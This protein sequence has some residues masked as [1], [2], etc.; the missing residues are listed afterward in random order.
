MGTEN[1]A[2][3]ALSV[4]NPHPLKLP[5]PDLL[6]HLVRSV[7]ELP[8]LDALDGGTRK[9]YTYQQ[10]HNASE[11]IARRL[12]QAH[13]AREAEFVVPVLVP[14][15]PL[16]YAAL[17]GTLKAGGAFCPLNID[18]PSERVQ[19]ILDDVDASVVVVSRELAD[20]LPPDCSQ[21]IITIEFDQ[22]EPPHTNLIHRRAC[23]EDLAYVMYT[24]GS[25]GTPK[26]VGITHDAATQALL[27]H[28]RHIPT[29]S[30]FLQ[31]AAPTFDVSVFEIFFPLF[32]GCTLVTVRRAELLNDL[33][34][35]MREMEVDACE[36]TPTVA[37]SLLRSRDSV[38][39]LKLVLTIGEMLSQPV[40]REFGGDESRA[41]MLWAMYGPTEAT[42]HW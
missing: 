18:A 19:F 39:S 20:N 40:I 16:L 13:P 12:T 41:S 32:R 25:T 3:A 42:I 36:L 17:L 24:S 38:P 21:E 29:F 34:S 9:T 30:R 31:F 1:D 10:L 28:D 15:S 11:V 5:G 6:H 8:A 22:N 7:S 33:P 35:A 23:A 4:L 37:G 27:S 26:G 14:Q 2:D